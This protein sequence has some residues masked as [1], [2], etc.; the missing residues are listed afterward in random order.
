MTHRHGSSPPWLRAALLALAASLL[1]LAFAATPAHAVKRVIDS[2]VP[3]PSHPIHELGIRG[4]GS[5]SPGGIFV[6]DSSTADPHDGEIYV[7]DRS[8]VA[9]FDSDLNFIRSFGWDVIRPGEAGNIANNERQ[10]LEVSATAGSFTLSFGGGVNFSGGPT[11]ALDFDADPSEVESA[12]NALPLMSSEQQQLTVRATGGTFTLSFDPDGPGGAPAQTTEPLDFD[13]LDAAGSEGGAVRDALE[14]LPAIDDVFVDYGPGDELGSNPYTITF[15]GSLESTDVPELSVDDSNLTG[16]AAT[17]AITTT[18]E[19]NSPAVSVTG[20]PGDYEIEFD[21]PPLADANVPQISVDDSGLTGDATRTTLEHGAA[22]EV[23]EDPSTCKLAS[24]F[25]VG[26]GGAMNL[27]AFLPSTDLAIDQSDGSLYVADAGNDRIQKFAA[28][29]TFLWAA[30]KGVNADGAP[31]PDLCLAGDECKA[32]VSDGAEASLDQAG[33]IALD[34]RDGDLYVYDED[35]HRVQVFGSGGAFKF[36]WGVNVN[37]GGQMEACT[38]GCQP[39]EAASANPNDDPLTGLAGGVPNV[40]IAVG[41]QGTVYLTR[42]GSQSTSGSITEPAAIRTFA[43][44]ENDPTDAGVFAADHYVSLTP[45]LGELALDSGPTAAS[46]DDTVYVVAGDGATGSRILELS[47]DGSLVDANHGTFDSLRSGNALAYDPDHGFAG[48]R[49]LLTRGQDFNTVV[50]LDDTPPPPAPEPQISAAAATGPDTATLN[51]SVDPNDQPSAYRFQYVDEDTYDADGGSF[52]HALLAPALGEAEIPDDPPGTDPLPVAE[53]IVELNPGTTYHVRLLA[54]AT[55]G[56]NFTTTLASGETTFTTDPAPPAASP[57]TVSATATSA[58][59]AASVDPHGAETTYRFQYGTEGPCSDSANACLSTPVQSAG[60]A[61]GP[62]LVTRQITGLQSGAT[63][64][65]RLLAESALGE[66]ST[67]DRTVHVIPQS[68]LPENRAYEKVSLDEKGGTEAGL[69]FVQASADGDALAYNPRPNTSF[70]HDLGSPG[71]QSPQL[72]SRGPGGQWSTE[73]LA[74]AQTPHPLAEPFYRPLGYTEDLSRQLVWLG[75][76]TGVPGDGNGGYVRDNATD[77]FIEIPGLES[78]TGFGSGNNWFWDAQMQRIAFGAA[79]DPITPE[80]PLDGNVYLHT[81]SQADG[82]EL[83]SKTVGGQIVPGSG[84]GVRPEHRISAGG[85]RVF[86]TAQ[87]AGAG[88]VDPLDTGALFAR[89]G[90]ETVKVSASERTPTDP[91]GDG[92]DASYQDATAD[93]ELVFF[94]SKEKLTDDATASQDGEGIFGGGQGGGELYRYDFSAPEGERLTDLTPAPAAPDGAEVAGLVEMSE[95][96]GRLYFLALAKLAPGAVPGAPNLYLWQENGGAPAITH[97]ATVEQG[98]V[99]NE[100]GPVLATNLDTRLLV[101][102]KNLRPPMASADATR[103]AFRSNTKLTASPTGGHAQVYLYDAPADRLE[104]VSCPPSGAAPSAPARLG[105][106]DIGLVDAHQLDHHQ[107]RSLSAAGGRVFF[108]TATPLLARDT[109]G[110]RDVYEWRSGQLHL[111]SSGQHGQDST[112]VDADVD[113][114]NVF[115]A[116]RERLVSTDTDSVMDIY[117][118]RVDGVSPPPPPD[119]PLC[120]G[121][122]CFP[123]PEEPEDPTPASAADFEPGNVAEGGANPRRCLRPARTAKRHS[124]RAKHARRGLRRAARAS[125]RRRVVRLRRVARRHARVAKQNA[126][127][128]KRCRRA[129]RAKANADRRANR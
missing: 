118:A 67:P 12:L 27:S 14:A 38:S 79:D 124:N 37:D 57:A 36:M 10:A 34:P 113:G 43:D 42:P 88:V 107:L 76:A 6:N 13:A 90:G 60:A 66:A 116:S 56:Y 68:E 24:G 53:D 105:V 92:G 110:R 77:T 123:L 3:P 73:P 96:G 126:N 82:S 33:K 71:L 52:E 99:P 109:N 117:V 74:P 95:D 31:D 11:P 9:V 39:G 35:N 69:Q 115:F 48:D 87:S 8:R 46:A 102:R 5:P 29:G 1:A 49:L 51:G 2:F 93:G 75:D 70:P 111:I 119:P 28:D 54:R 58:L 61:G 30:G 127:R 122:S 16:G 50:V 103:F 120:E 83:I 84:A 17:A 15:L 114:D 59:L 72:A 62:K 128:A 80:T 32:G 23:C 65:Y 22:Y 63:Y 64:H 40:D 85:E 129:V 106:Q 104:C 19:G 125:N 91:E 41:D 21:G 47:A 112:F 26:L 7:V 4:L 94:I 45:A 97:V 78:G 121:D 108:Q 55:F 86:W 81:W 101:P 89:D 98:G 20:T 25:S 18:A 44:P 100:V